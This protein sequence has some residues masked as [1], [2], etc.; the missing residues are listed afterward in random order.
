MKIALPYEY[1]YVNQ[2][3]GRSKEFTIV[4]LNEGKTVSQKNVS[5]EDLQHNHEGLAG[6]MKNENVDVVI[7]GGIGARALAPL[8]EGGLEV[9]TG[10]SGKITEVIDKY[11]RGELKSSSEAC[12]NHHGDHH[13]HGCS[14]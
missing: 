12:C 3:F 6:L 1:G 11:V 2:H 9:V 4:E 14:H 8:K 13:D 5:A 10:V 7:V